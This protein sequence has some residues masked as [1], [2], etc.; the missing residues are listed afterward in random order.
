MLMILQSID[1]LVEEAKRDNDIRSYLLRRLR[2]EQ[3][4]PRQP[5]PS[6]ALSGRLSIYEP[7]LDAPASSAVT[8]HPSQVEPPLLPILLRLGSSRITLDE[9]S[10]DWRDL[11]SRARVIALRL[12][13]ISL[14]KRNLYSS[15]ER[16]QLVL[17]I[18]KVGQAL[19]STAS[20]ASATSPPVC[21]IL[22][23]NDETDKVLKSA[24]VRP[25]S[26][27]SVSPIEQYL[28]LD[29]STLEELNLC[30][31]LA[32]II[33]LRYTDLRK[34]LLP[35]GHLEQ[36]MLIHSKV[37]LINGTYRAPVPGVADPATWLIGDSAA[38][39]SLDVIWTVWA[40]RKTSKE[41]GGLDWGLM[42][43]HTNDKVTYVYAEDTWDGTDDLMVSVLN[44]EEVR[45]S[46]QIA[47]ILGSIGTDS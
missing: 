25:D 31:L 15:T 13:T 22:G 20:G 35:P 37:L 6:I 3:I 2:E 16:D 26:S 8:T 4:L 46:L 40:N 9:K 44:V 5:T 38:L 34:S 39:E 29:S 7:D 43:V 36:S 11:Q 28:D 27:S 23:G 24:M 17:R 14:H 21:T 19:A 33:N 42:S 10:R 18:A 45:V 41:G 32:K 1:T 47:D 12:G 30:S